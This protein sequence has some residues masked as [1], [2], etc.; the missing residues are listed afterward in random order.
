MSTSTFLKLAVTT[1]LA[2]GVTA[3]DHKSKSGAAKKSGDVNAQEK[4]GDC[5]GLIGNWSTQDR[6]GKPSKTLEFQ[7]LRT[8]DGTMS[9]D[10]KEFSKPILVNGH[11]QRFEDVT[12]VSATCSNG[13]ISLNV[14]NGQ[15]EKASVSTFDLDA[16][17]GYGVVSDGKSQIAVFQRPLETGLVKDMTPKAKQQKDPRQEQIEEQQLLNDKPALGTERF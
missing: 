11:S 2:I 14:K 9:L 7:I 16:K 8:E 1:A 6:E 12:L 15:A 10:L 13:V 17:T 3:C 4:A 5:A